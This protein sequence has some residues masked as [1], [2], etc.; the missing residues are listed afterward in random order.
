MEIYIIVEFYRVYVELCID[1]YTIQLYN[2][3]ILQ[4]I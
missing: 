1:N 2:Y 4:I 3:T